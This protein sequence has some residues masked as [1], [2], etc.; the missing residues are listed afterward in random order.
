MIDS[1]TH[2]VSSKLV[3]GFKSYIPFF[4][5]LLLVS[6]SFPHIT[7]GLV[8]AETSPFPLL[9]AF[10]LICLERK[11]D[12]IF[13]YLSLFL[14]FLWAVT[15]PQGINLL[16][17]IE[18]LFVY[19]QNVFVAFYIFKCGLTHISKNF[20]LGIIGF[21]L[22]TG[23][24]F[25]L[26]FNFLNDIL[27]LLSSERLDALI[28]RGQGSRFFS[29]EPSEALGSIIFVLMLYSLNKFENRNFIIISTLLITTILSSSGTSFLL[30]SIFLIS[31]TLYK[32]KLRI[33]LPITLIFL[34]IMNYISPFLLTL[35]IDNR[36]FYLFQTMLNL[37]FFEIISLINLTSGFRFTLDF[38]SF[39]SIFILQPYYG[40]G[41]ASANSLYALSSFG[42][43][44]QNFSEF[45]YQNIKNLK[46][47]SLTA[48]MLLELGILGLLIIGLFIFRM[49]EYFKL[50]L[51]SKMFSNFEKSLFIL[52]VFK[53]IFIMIVGTPASL[54]LV[55]LMFYFIREKLSKINI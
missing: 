5:K 37:S 30:T 33:L 23:I 29:T 20:C 49:K 9:I 43:D 42:V 32:F 4:Q 34:A 16:D 18:Q 21:H 6:I 38:A 40:I 1:S 2:N 27:V 55:F 44:L 13:I 3:E 51:F 22:A 26:G 24:V 17:G 47:T 50:I 19:F 12:S 28:N 14:I 15:I 46:P 39:Y 7:L 11:I 45:T 41:T 36:I 52:A 25:I 35:D 8:P 31:Y 54:A 53:L 10:V 48:T